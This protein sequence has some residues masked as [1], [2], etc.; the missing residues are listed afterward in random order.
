MSLEIFLSDAFTEVKLVKT[1]IKL[2]S[3]IRKQKSHAHIIYVILPG[4][5]ILAYC[6]RI[7]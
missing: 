7:M 1:F 3:I 2:I 4:E 6:G 5:S